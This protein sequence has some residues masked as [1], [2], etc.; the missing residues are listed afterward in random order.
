VPYTL[1][2]KE[3]AKAEI[4]CLPKSDRILVERRIQ[5][6]ANNPRQVGTTSLKG[7]KFSGL[8]RIRAGNYRI[9]YQIRDGELIVIVVRVGNRRDVYD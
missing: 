7:K 6:L 9:I 4:E 5:S 2:I 3:S 1:L 8:R